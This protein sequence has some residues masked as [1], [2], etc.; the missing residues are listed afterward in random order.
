MGKDLV[1]W[2]SGGGEFDAFAISLSQKEVHILI[3]DTTGKL[4]VLVIDNISLG[5]TIQPPPFVPM[6]DDQPTQLQGE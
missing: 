2:T 1:S 4:H 3:G 6:R 5:G